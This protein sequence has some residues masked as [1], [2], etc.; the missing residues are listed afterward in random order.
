MRFFKFI[1][2]IILLQ[3]CNTAKYSL[4]EYKEYNTCNNNVCYKGIIPCEVEIYISFSEISIKGKK[5]YVEGI[6]KDYDNPVHWCNVYLG[7]K[8]DDT[9][10]LQKWIAATNEEG[11]FKVKLKE[12]EFIVFKSLGYSAKIYQLM[13]QNQTEEEKFPCWY[14]IVE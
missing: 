13:L 2:L 1:V 5:I 7:K 3:S 6:V 4:I 11:R 14:K 8:T 12:G 10:F 9:I